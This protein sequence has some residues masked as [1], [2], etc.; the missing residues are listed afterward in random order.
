MPS[1]LQVSLRSG[2]RGP[3]IAPCSALRC[4]KTVS[5]P[6][7][8]RKAPVETL[9]E[10]AVSGTPCVEADASWNRSAP[11][12]PRRQPE[13]RSP[14][15]SPGQTAGPVEARCTGQPQGAGASSGLSIMGERGFYTRRPPVALPRLRPGPFPES[16]GEAG[17]RGAAPV[18]GE[19]AP[20]GGSQQT[21][22]NRLAQPAPES[23][24][25][26]KLSAHARRDPANLPG[27]ARTGP[28]PSAMV[29][30]RPRRACPVGGAC[31]PYESGTT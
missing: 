12:L 31:V 17:A 4:P 30:P 24:V 1:R 13:C 20:I 5:R 23:P 15:S 21:R 7:A 19:T 8:V 6:G 29:T 14:S 16:T 25:T 11:N 26:E 28:R 22:T 3:W 2:K 10:S 27:D 18:T 9:G